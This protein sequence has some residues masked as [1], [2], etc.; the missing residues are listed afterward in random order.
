ML[1]RQRR[2]TPSDFARSL[3]L[4]VVGGIPTG[5]LHFTSLQHAACCP[6]PT[7]TR[8]EAARRCTVTRWNNKYAAVHFKLCTRTAKH[9]KAMRSPLRIALWLP[10]KYYECL[11]KRKCPHL[12]LVASILPWQARHDHNGH[13]LDGAVQ[14]SDCRIVSGEGKRN[15]AGCESRVVEIQHD[16][17]GPI[18]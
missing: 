3:P 18:A 17:C 8:R 5:L 15:G 11:S 4:Y 9:S 12:L 16:C 10:Q 7:A 14:H 2:S 1:T 13:D 6:C